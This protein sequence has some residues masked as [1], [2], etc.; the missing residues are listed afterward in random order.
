MITFIENEATKLKFISRPLT[1]LISYSIILVIVS[2]FVWWTVFLTPVY[3]SLS[4]DRLNTDRIDCFLREKSLL[5]LPLLNT[6]IKNLKN[7]DRSIFDLGN[8]KQIT[9]RANPDSSSFKIFG[10]REKYY[11]PSKSLTLFT[12]NPKFGFKMFQ[13]RSQL[14]KFIK[15]ELK[16]QSITVSQQI[17]W[18]ILFAVPVFCTPLVTANWLLTRPF[19]T[20]YEFDGTNRKLIVSVKRILG[21]DIERVYGFDRIDRVFIDKKNLDMGGRIMLQFIPEY[22]YPIEEF[23]DS[24]YGERNYKIIDEFIKRYK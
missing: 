8:G 10:D 1:K 3:S 23:L 18:F 2:P 13:Q 19:K 11:Y 9:L 17:G 6:E 4:C 24:E 15:G 20:V 5:N 12:L 21:T 14:A 7:V 16:Q 22:N